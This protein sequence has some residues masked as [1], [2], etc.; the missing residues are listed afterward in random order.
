MICTVFSYLNL[1]PQSIELTSAAGRSISV[2]CMFSCVRPPKD[3]PCFPLLSIVVHDG[4]SQMCVLYCCRL[5]AKLV[6][7]QELL[8]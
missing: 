6:R 7:V 4:L 1:D 8:L 5:F 2:A 3:A